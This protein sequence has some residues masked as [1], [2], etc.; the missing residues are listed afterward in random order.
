MY[1]SYAKLHDSSAWN[2][3]QFWIKKTLYE[4]YLLLISLKI[5]SYAL[6]QYEWFHFQAYRWARAYQIV[7]CHVH[8]LVNRVKTLP[9]IFEMSCRENIIISY[10]ISF[11]ISAMATVINFW[12]KNNIFIFW[13]Q[14]RDMLCLKWSFKVIFIYFWYHKNEQT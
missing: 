5:A 3:L 13:I 7:L 14:T 9:S 6:S 4:I 10:Q 12:V 2:R 11:F 1:I 8:L